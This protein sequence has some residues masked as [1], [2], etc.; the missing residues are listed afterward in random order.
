[1]AL[2]KINVGTTANDGTGSTIRV[3]F[4]RTNAAMDA[5]DAIQTKIDTVESNADVTD[6]QNVGLSIH[7]AA[8]KTTPIDADTLPLID[9]AASNALKKVTWAN[10]KATIKTYLDTL[11][12]AVSHASTHVTGGTDKIRD[13]TA[14]Q[15][16]LMTSAYASKLD[17][18]S[19]GADVTATAIHGATA[20]TTPADA[21]T[22]PIIDSEASNALKKVTWANIKATIKTYFDTLYA[23]VAQAN[24]THTGDATGA[25]ALTLATVNS[26]VGSFTNANIT[27]NAKGLVTAASNGTGGG[28]STKQFTSSETQYAFTTETWED[29][30]LSLSVTVTTGQK[31]YVRGVVQAATPGNACLVGIR[32]MRDSTAIGVGT[33]TGS[34]LA[35]GAQGMSTS[36]FGAGTSVS[37]HV[38]EPAAGTYTYKVQARL[39]TGAGGAVYINRTAQN[40]DGDYQGAARS[41]LFT[42]VY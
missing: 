14:S 5:V 8:E 1:M 29:I 34:R 18:I 41:S 22:M 4:Q 32:L 10:I 21:D 15:D 9:S 7:G 17:G 12:S 6:A 33:P 35:V 20:K 42:E 26:N 37:E 23:T 39:M 25:T 3:A 38:D 11:Y 40:A 16:G 19:S 24:A 13:A 30:N 2:T 36:D 28:G 31:V 27:V